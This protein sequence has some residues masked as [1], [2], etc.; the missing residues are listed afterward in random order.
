MER[1]TDYQMLYVAHSLGIDLFKAVISLKKK[2]K[3]LPKEFY[4]NYFNTTKNGGNYADIM[5]L[6]NLGV[7][8]E[9]IKN[10]Y[11]ITEEGINQFKSQYND[12]VIY[13]P[14]KELDVEYLKHRINFYC[15]FYHY[16]YGGDNSEH[17]ISYYINYY[18]KGHYIS[19]TT[20]D[21]INQFKTDLKLY[22]KHN[23]IHS[24]IN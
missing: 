21:V 16:K 15:M 2:D 9:R 10:Y 11:Y 19:H 23:L 8:K 6:V 20:K 1:L 14:K 7:M 3:V 22:Y 13:K 12:L 17:V 4:R 5:I 24:T 18:L